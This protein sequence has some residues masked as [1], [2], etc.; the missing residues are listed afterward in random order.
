MEPVV[1]EAQA[2]A[3]AVA[4]PPTPPTPATADVYLLETP[5]RR[6]PDAAAPRPAK[7]R[8]PGTKSA[9]SGSGD[10]AWHRGKQLEAGGTHG[11]ASVDALDPRQQH[12]VVAAAHVGGGGAFLLA[13]LR[14]A[15]NSRQP[16]ER[17]PFHQKQYKTPKE[18]ALALETVSTYKASMRPDRLAVLAFAA[19]MFVA[20]GG[21]FALSTAGGAAGVEPGVRKLLAGVTFEVA[22]VFIVVFGGDLFTGNTMTMTVGWLVRAVKGRDVAR[23]LVISYLFNF[24][25]AVVGAAFFGYFT[26]LFWA[27]PYHTYVVELTMAKLTAPLYVLFL[28]GIACNWLVCLAVFISLSAESIEGKILASALPV[29]TFAAI[30]FEHC[31]ANMFYVPLGLMYGAPSNFGVFIYYNLLLVTL[32][33]IIGGAF[34]MGAAVWWVYLEGRRTPTKKDV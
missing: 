32:G 33:N 8:K 23:V 26:E 4:L 29:T 24:L 13:A 22:L 34:F 16:G 11:S 25:G 12:H 18:V 7:K 9:S 2:P 14:D 17:K 21:L 6:P 31:V 20:F 1:D 28:K 5:S 19:G 30:G 10:L 27:Q 15:L 3:T